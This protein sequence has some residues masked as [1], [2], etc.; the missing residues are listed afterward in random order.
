MEN[1][2]KKNV[3]TATKMEESPEALAKKL[4]DKNDLRIFCIA[5]MAALI[6]LAF[7]HMGRMVNRKYF[8]K[9][10]VASG[11]AVKG[12]PGAPEPGKRAGKGGKRPKRGPSGW[13]LF[14]QAEAYRADGDP[15]RA[16]KSYARAAEKGMPAAMHRLGVCYFRGEGVAKD[17]NKAAELL[18]KAANAGFAPSK[19]M[20]EKVEKALKAAAPNAPESSRPRP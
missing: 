15:A 14:Q 4:R 18:R 7:Y 19:A 13:D 6:V 11:K 12:A 16:A 8:A 5:F 2:E 1:E 17:L 9:R 3:D 10:A 20:L